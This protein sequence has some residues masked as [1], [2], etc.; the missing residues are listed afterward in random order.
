LVF[1]TR[2]ALDTL[3]PPATGED[4]VRRLVA[5]VTPRSA[6]AFSLTMFFA[7]IFLVSVP[8]FI[9]A[10]L[11]RFYPWV[12]LLLTPVLFG[13][14]Y[15]WQQGEKFTH[16]GDLLE[17]FAW[18]W[19]AGSIYWGWFRWEPLW[20]LPME[21]IGLPFALWSIWRGR[22][23]LGNFF[24]VGSLFG[25]VVT[26]VYFYLTR[27]MPYW[28]SLMRVDQELASSILHVALGQ[29]YTPWGLT[30]AISLAM[31]LLAVSVFALQGRKPHWWAFSGAVV[32]TIL[33]DGLFWLVAAFA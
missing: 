13:L 22:S 29:I 14:S 20:H 18:T 9:Q 32:S 23:L 12:S 3:R 16:W 27:L 19:L 33:V 4:G 5:A 25:T 7:A 8:V 15:R 10:P 26:D 6:V 21:A 2:T 17:G 24:F 31:L 30:C 11:V 1:Y 28:R